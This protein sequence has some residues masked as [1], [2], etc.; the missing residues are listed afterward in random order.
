MTA[1]EE[2]QTIGNLIYAHYASKANDEYRREH[3]GCSEI[4]NECERALWLSFRWA[5]RAK[6]EG[7]ILRLFETG[8]QEE[9]RI[10][11][12][13]RDCDLIVTE[14]DG[15]GKQHSYSLFGGHLGGSIDGMVMGVP[16]APTT[17]HLLEMKT[18]NDKSFKDLTKRGVSVSKPVYWAQTQMYMGLSQTQGVVELNRCLYVAVNKNTD[19]I[20][21]ETYSYDARAYQILY[22]KALRIIKA[23]ESPFRIFNDKEKY[24]CAWCSY[25]ATCWGDATADKNCRTCTHAEP[26]DDGTWF[27]NQLQKRISYEEQLVGCEQHAMIGGL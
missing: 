22:A 3:L 13:L 5:E 14:K 18:H 6:F 19:E 21:S 11:R 1:P 17:W 25:K 24:P 12:N 4:G 2:F 20:Y 9:A 10:V 26:Q 7:R 8:K 23:K 27:C 16:E 15:K